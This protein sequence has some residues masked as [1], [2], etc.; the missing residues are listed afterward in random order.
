MAELSTP[1]PSSSRA[2]A[3]AW[4]VVSQIAILAALAGWVLLV[5]LSFMA[6]DAG[7][8]IGA[9][10][11]TLLIL[12]WTWPLLAL[13]C[14]VWAWVAFKRG[15]NRKALILMNFPFAFAAVVVGIVGVVLILS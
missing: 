12:L 7:T 2:G 8:D 9:G 10:P 13:V 15:K 3:V 6:F 5:G 11:W 1:R 4:L 14:A